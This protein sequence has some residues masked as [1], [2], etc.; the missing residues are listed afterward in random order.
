MRYLV[1]MGT[2][3]TDALLREVLDELRYFRE[4]FKRFQP[5]LERYEEASKAKG[6]LQ[7]RRIMKGVGTNGNR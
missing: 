4:Q 1:S 5:F 2:E 6:M 7:Q 3:E